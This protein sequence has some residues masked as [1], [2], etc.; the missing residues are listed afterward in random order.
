MAA[1]LWISLCAGAEPPPKELVQYIAEAQR[2][3]LDEETIRRNAANGGWDAKLVEQAFRDVSSPRKSLAPSAGLELPEGYRIG[4]G[5][6]LAVSVWKEPEASVDGV[7]VR[8]DGKVSL[9][10]VKE[11]EVASLTPTEAEK[12]LS[13]RFAK[14]LLSPDVTVIVKAIN[15]WKVYLVGAIRGVG[16]I[17]LDSRMTVLQAITRAGGLT[18]YAKRKRIYILRNVNGKQTRLPFNYEAVIR[19]EQIEQNIELEPDDTIVIPH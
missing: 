6:V 1:G 15:S 2:L 7:V 16:S 3:G 17:N 9:P 13:Q 10:L 8:A 4:A 19:G 11:V 12:M 5:D 14:F 18:D